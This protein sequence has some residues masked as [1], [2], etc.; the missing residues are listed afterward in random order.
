[1]CFKGFDLQINRA[2]DVDKGIPL[3]ARGDVN[4]AHLVGIDAFLFQLLKKVRLS[5]G[6]EDRI[7][8]RFAHGAVIGVVDAAHG[9]EHHGRVHG[10]NHF[11]FE[12]ANLAYQPLAQ[13][14]RV[15]D[16]AIGHAQ[17]SHITD[18]DN[19]RRGQRFGLT[20]FSRLRLGHPRLGNTDIA[21]GHQDVGDFT[22]FLHPA[23]NRTSRAKFNIIG[24]G[25]NRHRPVGG[26]GCLAH[27][28]Q[29]LL[30]VH[31]LKIGDWI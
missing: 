26:I 10:D 23:G 6:W 30:V 19:F 17:E 8:R 12:T 9:G 3:A 29:L 14:H 27:A 24:M 25:H 16:H 5:T 22:A 11:G 13:F 28:C 7:H 31:Y 4:L 20:N 18:A 21:A 15:F 1:M 2:A